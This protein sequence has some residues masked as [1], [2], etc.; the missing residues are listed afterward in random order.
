MIWE[1]IWMFCCLSS[2]QKLGKPTGT[3]RPA[4]LK[5]LLGFVFSA[6]IFAGI[7]CKFLLEFFD[8]Q[9]T[10]WELIVK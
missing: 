9:R 5:G 1:T 2:V 10:S 7:F 3:I 4:G 8:H 6:G